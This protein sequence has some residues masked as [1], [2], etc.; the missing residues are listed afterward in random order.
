MSL[1]LL[2]LLGAIAGA[3]V[4][5]VYVTYITKES[6]LQATKNAMK[7]D[8]LK[9]AFKAR[10][11]EKTA[12]SIKLDVLDSMSNSICEVIINGQDVAQDVAQGDVLYV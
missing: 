9:K 6:A 12:T 10:I 1:L 5:E 2:M 8:E 3:V 7:T 11:K 4:Y